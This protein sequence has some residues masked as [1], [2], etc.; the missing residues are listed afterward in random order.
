M[1]DYDSVFTMVKFTL[2]AGILFLIGLFVNETYSIVKLIIG[3]RTNW[4]PYLIKLAIFI[5]FLLFVNFI[6]HKKLFIFLEDRREREELVDNEQ[7]RIEGFLKD[8]LEYNSERLNELIDDIESA[9]FLPESMEP[10]EDKLNEKISQA[11]KLVEELKHKERIEQLEM[12][13]REE[14][15]KLEKI[16]IEQQELLKTEEQ[17]KKDTLK[18]LNIEE[19]KVFY[20]DE[21]SGEELEVLLENGFKQ[22]NEYDIFEKENVTVLV[23]QILNHS[24][25][26]TFLAWSVFSFLRANFPEV[27]NLKE[28]ETRD[29]DITFDF[30]GKTFALEIEMGNLLRKK[31]QLA[32]KV[33][34][35]NRKYKKRWM[36]L[37]SNKNLVSK[38]RKH[39]IT[40]QRKDVGENIEKLMKLNT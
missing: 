30:E 22:K 6:A 28:H 8:K 2:I 15:D 25:T 7:E 27:E 31:K 18:S 21:L 35:L 1:I 20:A 19:T 32:E 26:H 40:T 37:V 38:Y 13:T 24:P 36:F 12:K 17:E 16:K 11:K 3:S 34:Y 29:A 9:D 4:T 39:G 33:K 14:E 23:K 10:F 5:P